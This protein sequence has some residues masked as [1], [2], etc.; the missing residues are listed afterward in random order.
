MLRTTLWC[1]SLTLIAACAALDDTATD[2]QEAEMPGV[3]LSAGMYPLMNSSLTPL[4]PVN[5]VTMQVFSTACVGKPDGTPPDVEADFAKQGANSFAYLVYAR[6]RAQVDDALAVKIAASVSGPTAGVSGEVEASNTSSTRAESVYLLGELVA[7][8]N[9]VL[10]A[11]CPVV[12]TQDSTHTLL[13]D[14]AFPDVPA[15][16]KARYRAAAFMR[17]CGDGWTHTRQMGAGGTL[18]LEFKSKT[19]EDK[20]AIRAELEAS[21]G[22]AVMGGKIG[23]S[24]AGS[25]TKLNSNATMHTSLVARGAITGMPS[26]GDIDTDPNKLTEIVGKLDELVN[27]IRDAN[28]VD[29]LTPMSARLATYDG[30]APWGGWAAYPNADRAKIRAALAQIKPLAE[31]MARFL[32]VRANLVKELEYDLAQ[33]KLITDTYPT[34]FNYDGNQRNYAGTAALDRHG[35]TASYPDLASYKTKFEAFKTAL[36]A[37]MNACKDD[38]AHGFAKCKPSATL[39]GQA[40]AEIRKWRTNRP[41]KLDV[42]YPGRAANAAAAAPLCGAAGQLVEYAEA[43]YAKA[44]SMATLP[45]QT[46]YDPWIGKHPHWV[47]DP[48]AGEKCSSGSVA[49]SRAYIPDHG[50]R[51]RICGPTW[52][53]PALCRRRTGLW[54]DAYWR[55]ELDL[56]GL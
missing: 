27:V 15:A 28:R 25:K 36:V 45:A 26:P 54:D 29:N 24:V 48:M 13:D 32:T 52:D 22:R 11:T 10:K 2:E 33:I 50:W 37:E 12:L 41:R 34:H 16:D 30:L 17:S 49:H 53:V 20:L 8:T 21:F 5:S 6:S 9:H 44:Y 40:A 39:P 38:G 23:A 43:V 55:N 47:S 19:A 42:W 31:E 4:S 3:G 7:Y 35:T 46:A 56:T 1:A 18:I 14:E 51:W